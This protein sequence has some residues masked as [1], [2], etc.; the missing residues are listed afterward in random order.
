MIYCPILK[1]TDYKINKVFVINKTLVPINTSFS[2][3]KS[4]HAAVFVS[5]YSSTN[6]CSIQLLAGKRCRWYMCRCHLLCL[7]RKKEKKKKLKNPQNIYDT[8][9]THHSIILVYY[10]SRTTQPVI[11]SMNICLFGRCNDCKVIK[12][13]KKRRKKYPQQN[14]CIRR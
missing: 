5:K 10:C 3:F 11:V 2:K 7:I 4:H 12:L 13:F 9:K 1:F 8:F 14:T 6:C